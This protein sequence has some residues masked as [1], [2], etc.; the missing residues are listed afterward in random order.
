[1]AHISPMR[2]LSFGLIAS[3]AED[4]D[5]LSVI[6]VNTE[7]P[8]AEMVTFADKASA[9]TFDRSKSPWFKLLKV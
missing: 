8:Y 4:W 7:K 5:D 6:Q 9:L 3:G 1:M 2:L